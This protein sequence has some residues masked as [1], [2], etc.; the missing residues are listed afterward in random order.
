MPNHPRALLAWPWDNPGPTKIGN[1]RGAY[2]E[3]KRMHNKTAYR[4]ALILAAL[5]LTFLL[6][7]CVCRPARV[8]MAY[9]TTP[10][11][12]AELE[13]SLP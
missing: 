6:D 8:G 3:E 9:Y 5:S 11:S 13:A 7:A 1:A 2:S 10:A 12:V 4:T